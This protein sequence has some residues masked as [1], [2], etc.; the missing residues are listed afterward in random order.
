MHSSV[1]RRTMDR[2]LGVIGL[3]LVGSL[4][5]AR[6]QEPIEPFLPPPSIPG[7]PAPQPEAGPSEPG[8]P[9]AGAEPQ[10][11]VVRAKLAIAARD[12]DARITT[13]ILEQLRGKAEILD[14]SDHGGTVV[15]LQRAAK[16]AGA[17]SLLHIR[18]AKFKVNPPKGARRTAGFVPG[19]IE[20]TIALRR[21]DLDALG[22][23][24]TEAWTDKLDYSIET[25]D[26][27]QMT[28]HMLHHTPQH[29]INRFLGSLCTVRAARTQS[30]PSGR[31][32]V[33][34]NVTNNSPFVLSNAA[35][36]DFPPDIVQRNRLEHL[37]QNA[38]RA[39]DRARRR[40]ER[41]ASR[42]G[43]PTPPPVEIGPIGIVET[44]APWSTATVEI[45]LDHRP[46]GKDWASSV[47]E[48][49]QPEKPAAGG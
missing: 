42:A 13:T 22:I 47:G 10:V 16:D 31:T 35:V 15:Q 9:N 37:L 32:G 49:L 11:E 38:A 23:R 41:Q 7:E 46:S 20:A 48:L 17:L 29:V 4:S 2:M 39:A 33:T 1:R 5:V 3:L 19:S 8:Q 43:Q 28:R 24:W 25:E 6:A 45:R 21:D 36:T 40:A 26:Q 44:I 18:G 14:L 27:A 12:V 34:L 30:L